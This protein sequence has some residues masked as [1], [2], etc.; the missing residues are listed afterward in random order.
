MT[1][2]ALLALIP[3][4]YHFSNF[5]IFAYSSVI[6]PHTI[7]KFFSKKYKKLYTLYTNHYNIQYINLLSSVQF[8]KKLYTN[9]T[10]LYTGVH[11]L[12]ENKVYRCVQQCIVTFQTIH[13]LKPLVISNISAVSVQMYS[14]SPILLF[15]FQF[16]LT[17][18]NHMSIICLINST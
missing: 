12:K 5:W 14:F 2:S 15:I 9:Y 13:Y 10:L 17:Y 1:K 16:R 6:F 7:H 8:A 4:H 11:L 3:P 18:I